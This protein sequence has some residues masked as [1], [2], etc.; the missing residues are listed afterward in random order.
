[1]GA[2]LRLLPRRGGQTTGE[3]TDGLAPQR[4]VLRELLV[5]GDMSLYLVEYA[6]PRDQR[7]LQRHPGIHYR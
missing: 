6:I 7:T 1:M 3:I 5:H 2:W 4:H